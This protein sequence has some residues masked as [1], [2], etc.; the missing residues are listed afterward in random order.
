MRH[1]FAND[2]LLQQ[3]C[4]HLTGRNNTSLKRVWMNKSPHTRGTTARADIILVF[5]IMLFLQLKTKKD[6]YDNEQQLPVFNNEHIDWIPL[7]WLHLHSR[8]F[9]SQEYPQPIPITI[10]ITL[11]H[12]GRCL[13]LLLRIRFAHPEIIRDHI[14]ILKDRALSFIWF[15]LKTMGKQRLVRAC[16]VQRKT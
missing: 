7:D 2:M 16:G 14:G 9:F 10:E 4:T 6:T 11:L 8:V 3:W 1:D 5:M 13:I 15:L 12:I